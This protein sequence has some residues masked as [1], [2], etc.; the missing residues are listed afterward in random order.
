MI[1]EQ[2]GVYVSYHFEHDPRK[3]K[4]TYGWKFCTDYVPDFE[5]GQIVETMVYVRKPGC[6]SIAPYRAELRLRRDVY[7][8][9]ILKKGD[10]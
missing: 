10:N 6:E 3:P 9:P 1:E 7:G 8:N 2:Q 5:P 4:P